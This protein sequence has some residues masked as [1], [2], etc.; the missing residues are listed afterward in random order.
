[1]YPDSEQLALISPVISVS[2][3]PC[4]RGFSVQNSIKTKL[5][6]RLNPDKLNRIIMIRLVGRS[7]EDVD[8]QTA[9]QIRI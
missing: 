4:E 9:A 7:F 5:R 2:R 8:F 1:M 6:N 3:A